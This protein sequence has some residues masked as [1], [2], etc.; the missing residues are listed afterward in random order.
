MLY[1]DDVDQQ[2]ISSARLLQPSPPSTV[3]EKDQKWLA[4]TGRVQGPPRLAMVGA[5]MFYIFRL[6]E[7]PPLALAAC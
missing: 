6:F 7:E 3:I 4:A 1:L 5:V 2:G